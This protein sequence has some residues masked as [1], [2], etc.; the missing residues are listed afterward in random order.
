MKPRRTVML[1]IFCLL[2]LPLLARAE[3]LP[4]SLGFG[5]AEL[6]AWHEIGDSG[7]GFA[8]LK[9]GQHNFLVA[10]EKNASGWEKRFTAE[11]ALPD[12]PMRFLLQD[13][14]D[15]YKTVVEGEEFI[16]DR[17]K[18]GQALVVFWSNGEYYQNQFTY[19]LSSTGRWLLSNYAHAGQSGLIDVLDGE[20][21][22][23]EAFEQVER[24]KVKTE[25][26]LEQFNYAAF[27]RTARR[28][29]QP[30]ILPP[31][32]PEGWLT[33]REIPFEG[34]GLLPVY[35]A[36]SKDSLRAAGGKAALSPKGWVQVFGVEGDFALVSYG[37]SKNHHRVGYVEKRFLPD[38]YLE[39]GLGFTRVPALVTTAVGATDDPLV[40]REAL[41]RLLS[42]QTVT[43]LS[44]LGDL[45]YFE[46]EE[47]GKTYR[48]FA[49]L[50]AFDQTPLP[51]RPTREAIFFLEGQEQ[52]GVFTRVSQ[53]VLSFEIWVDMEHFKEDALQ[54]DFQF[55]LND[56]HLSSPVRFTVYTQIS[57]Q[58]DLNEAFAFLGD[59]FKA[60]GYEVS[61]LDYAGELGGLQHKVNPRVI[62]AQKGDMTARA[63]LAI[64]DKA[65][66][67]ALVEYPS[68]A[69][70]GW[71]AR[72]DFMQ[73]TLQEIP[74]E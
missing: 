32:L 4:D 41:A 69:A 22:F 48:A 33:A 54:N 63:Y 65:A 2:L 16:F 51:P 57:G 56:N 59:E 1:L 19:E 67:L 28:A 68:Q 37:I 29:H 9:E 25:R 40:S 70:E 66:F 12:G 6:V 18:W 49:P 44:K 17:D 21:V 39:E 31:S 50:S 27:P 46:A 72:M 34:E 53:D 3:A 23:Y 61:N 38:W 45:A 64:T 10:F 20:M 5:G 52:R 73:G 24:V 71:G 74:Q 14:S 43:L 60:K 35:S 11:R 13:A 15:T 47:Q 55:T 8:S 62:L 26:D 7:W 30:D 42:A 36:P 58:L